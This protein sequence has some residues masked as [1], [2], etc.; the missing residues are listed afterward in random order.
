VTWSRTYHRF[1]APQPNQRQGRIFLP[2]I[3]REAEEPLPRYPVDE[4]GQEEAKRPR[5]LGGR[6]IGRAVGTVLEAILQVLPW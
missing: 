2:R 3:R 6:K 5:R 1:M 4:S